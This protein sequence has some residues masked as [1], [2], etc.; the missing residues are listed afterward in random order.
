[1]S[2][3]T[4]DRVLLV[5]WDSASWDLVGP[6]LERGELPHLAGL[7][8]RGVMGTMISA[9]P[10]MEPMVYTSL[11]TGKFPDKHGV[12]GT[13][14]VYDRGREIRPITN[15]SR[16]SKAFWEILSQEN[17][18]CNI[19]HFPAVEPAEAINGVFV[20]RAFSSDP[21]S[22]YWDPF[23]VSE[24]CI[25]PDRHRAALTEA[26][27][28]LEDIDAETMRLFV[29][30][31]AELEPTDQRLLWIGT[32]LARTLSVHGAATWLM[33]NTDWRV[34]SV[35]YPAIEQLCHGFL[36]YAAPRLDWIDP[37][38]FECFHDVANS[39]V[40][41]CDLLLGRLL[42]L[43]GENATV[44]V[45]S[46]RGYL[47]HAH[48]PR[49]AVPVGPLAEASQHR[50]N[51]MF[52][53]RAPGAR[54]DELIHGA[55]EV[56]VCPTILRLCGVATGED[57]DG[58]VLTDAFADPPPE[59]Q[60]VES[61]EAVPPRRSK[62]IDGA[63]PVPWQELMRFDAAYAH[64][65]AML[66]QAEHDWNVAAVYSHSGRSP[67][68]VPLMTRLYYTNPLRTDMAPIVAEVLHSNGLIEEALTV[69]RNYV[70]CRFPGPAAAFMAG[71]VA[72][73]EGRELEAL[74]LFEEAAEDNPL[75]PH[76]HYYMG[77]VLRRTHRPQRALESFGRTVAID[78]QFVP[79]YLA[80]AQVHQAAGRYDSAVDAA[81][82][83]LAANFAH[84]PA[85]YTL[86][87]C[88]EHLGEQDRA[89]EAYET[90][91]RFKSD[92]GPARER[93]EALQG[94][95]AEPPTSS[96]P[97]DD[98]IPS[99]LSGWEVDDL[100]LAVGGVSKEV[101]AWANTYIHDLRDAETK[102]DAYLAENAGQLAADQLRDG[103][104]P[105]PTSP[106][107]EDGDFIIR[108]VMP[109]D[110][111]PLG[112]VAARTIADRYRYEVLVVHRADAD[113]LLGALMVRTSENP[114]GS[115]LLQAAVLSSTMIEF[116]GLSEQELWLKLIRAGVARVAA[117]GGKGVSVNMP[118][119]PEEFPGH[120]ELL[121]GLGFV[122][123]GQE[124]LLEMDLVRTRDRCL[125]LLEALREHG[126]IP[127]AIRCVPLEQVPIYQ[128]N[129]FLS[130]FFGDGAGPRRLDLDGQICQVVF[131]G[132]K[133]VAAFA[134]YSEDEAFVVQRIAVAE[135]YRTGYATP[136][137][138]G[139]GCIVGHEKGLTKIAMFTDE[140][141]FPDMARIA[142]R[143]GAEQIRA[144]RT[145]GLPLVVPWPADG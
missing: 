96:R 46:P 26:V 140:H 15:E 113:Q 118:G 43:T 53:L 80:M 3:V 143:L 107:A 136:M 137:L 103:P 18:P 64:R 47:S 36:R 109:A 7:V 77:E 22:N 19:V 10:L 105:E 38:D 28:T 65:L 8:K 130:E 14:K 89:R 50:P 145:M 106:P 139:E 144:T 2:N 138:I 1:M 81:L 84:A 95:D 56:D 40:R 34:T 102:L 134:G 35:N 124:V 13:H 104:L 31:F 5:G 127:E 110:L 133:I 45:C 27:V 117:G 33:D 132:G 101:T 54:Q 131:D 123:T 30:T 66:V 92:L 83:A 12:L 70:A 98:E 128:V 79:A 122:V 99:A 48:V 129:R 97:A 108:P 41:L 86:G 78:P 91:L 74:D 32:I 119:L 94:P 125:S 76:L 59:G 37:K 82:Q 135:G 49:G 6:L 24:G 11:A 73:L 87:V 42:E 63:P 60:T 17:V 25:C 52:V 141:S 4:D 9:K 61:W 51:G 16:R 116:Y 112:A 85:H 111:A 75:I 20:S 29:P 21:P 39:A 114:A 62:A 57:M 55:R 58:R 44:M 100:R 121:E 93:L 67:M 126:R 88:L 69:M 72:M 23:S 68:A 120:Q 71:A 115:V 90:A 142:R